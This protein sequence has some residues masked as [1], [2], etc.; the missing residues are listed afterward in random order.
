[1]TSFPVHASEGQLIADG[2]AK[3]RN[4]A[5]QDIKLA[6]STDSL[7][8]FPAVNGRYYIYCSVC[9]IETKDGF[10][11]MK[12][13]DTLSFIDP[14]IP[15]KVW[16][17]AYVSGSYSYSWNPKKSTIKF[18]NQEFRIDNC[19]DDTR[20][21][22]VNDSIKSVTLTNVIRND[23]IDSVQFGKLMV[24]G[25]FIMGLIFGLLI[26]NLKKIQIIIFVSVVALFS[27]FI[28]IMFNGSLLALSIPIGAFVLGNLITFVT[29]KLVMSLTRRKS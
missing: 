29:F 6:Q 2:I 26:K 9:P 7:G 4:T 16:L 13:L 14:D 18:E 25:L 23:E 19:W 20:A 28:Y 17:N 21:I 10:M 8:I 15:Q 24:F 3:A 5:N 11:L 27:F 1:M 12:I 22:L